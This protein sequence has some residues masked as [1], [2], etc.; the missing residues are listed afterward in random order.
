MRY[1]YHLIQSECLIN[2]LRLAI[3]SGLVGGFEP[4]RL[5]FES[6]RW[7]YLTLAVMSIKWHNVRWVLSPMLGTSWL[8]DR[9]Q[10]TSES[11]LRKIKNRKQY[12][13]WQIKWACSS[14][15]PEVCEREANKK[16]WA[17]YIWG[18]DLISV[19]WLLVIVDPKDQPRESILQQ[20][21][22][23]SLCKT[24]GHKPN[25]LRM[26]VTTKLLFIRGK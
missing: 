9:Y 19:C 16:F 4:H 7:H 10:Q 23:A 15:C 12:I 18:L 24:N 5:E 26:V 3:C 17:F 22:M 13:I 2:I 6:L 25:F 20:F 11:G 14:L 21:E 8:L 1:F